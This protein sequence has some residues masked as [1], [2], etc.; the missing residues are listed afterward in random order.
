MITSLGI[1]AAALVLRLCLTDKNRRSRR[2]IHSQRKIIVIQILGNEVVWAAIAAIS[3]VF[4]ALA[5]AG[6]FRKEKIVRGELYSTKIELDH[7][8]ERCGFLE[9]RLQKIDPERFIDKTIAL[10]GDYDELE[11]IAFDFTTC[12]SEAFGVAAEILAEQCIFDSHTLGLPAAMEAK[13]FAEIGLAANPSSKNLLAIKKTSEEYINCLANGEALE[14]IE[15]SGMSDTDLNFLSRKLA[16]QGKYVLAELA[17]RRSVRLAALRTG[18]KSSNFSGAIG[19][20]GITL[21]GLDRADEA[22]QRLEEAISVDEALGDQETY[23]YCLSLMYAGF[24][25]KALGNLRKANRYYELCLQHEQLKA[26][27]GE[28]YD[29]YVQ[30]SQRLKKEVMSLPETGDNNDMKK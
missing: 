21:L 23:G 7:W 25:W 27:C 29:D 30:A 10:A 2:A 9:E 12:Q 28:G 26:V 5:A 16:N 13:R 20:H 14:A 24:A 3:A 15:W 1:K 22:I 4:S 18:K 17:A 6:L 8:K 11:A 19:W